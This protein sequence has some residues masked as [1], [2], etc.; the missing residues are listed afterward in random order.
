[1]PKP[2][3]SDAQLQANLDYACGQGIDC[4]PI[5]PGGACFEPNTVAA[6]AAYAM[7]LLYQTAGK[8][9]WNCDFTQTAVLTSNNPSNF[10]T[11]IPTSS[12]LDNISLAPYNY[13][14][15]KFW[16]K[17]QAYLIKAPMG[18]LYFNRKEEKMI[19]ESALEVFLD[20]KQHREITLTTIK[21]M[22]PLKLNTNNYLEREIMIYFPF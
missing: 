4:S 1:M 20:A 3:V 15:A 7:N 19:S 5:Q 22:F 16:K 9:P 8:N 6:H 18:F 2:G 14:T 12:D 10:S 11:P 17:Y 13:H 21:S